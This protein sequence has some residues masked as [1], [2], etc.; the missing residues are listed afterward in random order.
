MVIEIFAQ[1]CDELPALRREGDGDKGFHRWGG[2]QL[3]LSRSAA[4]SISR[5]ESAVCSLTAA[6][7]PSKR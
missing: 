1:G 4:R 6:R 7:S 2:R 3:S 5:A